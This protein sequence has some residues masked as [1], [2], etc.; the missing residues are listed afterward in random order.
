MQRFADERTADMEEDDY[1]Q[2]FF[3]FRKAFFIAARVPK[4]R[5]VNPPGSR[6]FLVDFVGLSGDSGGG[7]GEKGEKKLL[8]ALAYMMYDY[9]GCVVETAIR[10]RTGGRLVSIADGTEY[11]RI[12]RDALRGIC[13]VGRGGGALARRN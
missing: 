1:V 8:D 13:G 6:A 5:G 2:T 10:T 12:K 4:G 9:V 3:E 7:G 11:V